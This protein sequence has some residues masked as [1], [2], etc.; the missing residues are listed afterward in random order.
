MVNKDRKMTQKITPYWPLHLIVISFLLF[1]SPIPTSASESARFYI[2]AE[3]CRTCH[4]DQSS[5]NQFGKWS[6]SKHAKSY[7]KLALQGSELITRLS[8]LSE[9]GFKSPICLGCHTTASNTEPWQRD[10]SFSFDEGISCEYCHGP[11]SEYAKEEIM[12]DQDAAHEAGLIF[13]G[14][15]V[16]I[17]CHQHKGSHRAVMVNGTVIFQH[18]KKGANYFDVAAAM[19]EIEHSSKGAKANSSSTDPRAKN[20]DKNY[21]G[22][23]VC[24]ACHNNHDSGYI[25]SHWQLSKHADSYGVLTTPEAMAIAMQKG[26]EAP[27]YEDECL[28]CHSTAYFAQAEANSLTGLTVGVGVQCEGCH[29][30]GNHYTNVKNQNAVHKNVPKVEEHTC[31]TCHNGYHGKDFNY[32]AAIK[33][34]AHPKAAQAVI[35]EAQVTYKTPANL[36]LNSAG[37]KLYVTCEASDSLIVID[38][39]E[40][41]VL[42]EIGVMNLPH[43]VTLSPDEKI[44]YVSNRGSDSVSVIDATSHLVLGTIDVGDEPH[45]LL[46]NKVGN[47]LVVANTGSHDISIV[48]LVSMKE[49]KRLAGGRGTW[50]LV[51]SPNQKEI[52]ATNNLSHLVP[53]RSSSLSELTV[54]DT[55]SMTVKNRIMIK[56]ANL[57]QGID[58]SPDGEFA[59]V[60]LLRTKNLVPIVRVL[61][62]WMI[63]NGFAIVWKDGSVDQLLIDNIDNHFADPTDV[64]IT[65]DGKYGLISGGGVDEI[66]VIDIE[67]VKRLLKNSKPTDRLHVI[68]NH[69]GVSENYV[70]SRIKVGRGP[71]GLATHGRFVYV[72]DALD[73]TISVIDIEKQKRV[74]IISLNGPEIITQVRRGE[75]IFHSADITYGRQYTCHSCHP[76]GGIDGLAYDISPDG[77]GYNP[78]DNRTLRGILDTAPFKWTGKNVSLSRQCG[79]RL[80]VFFTR[81][82]PFTPEQARDLESY[83]VTIPRNPNR[84]LRE[85]GLTP[86]QQRG[87]ELFNRDHTN[88]G[89]KIATIDRCNGCHSGPY[90][91]NRRVMNVGTSSHLDTHGNFDV[92][93]LNNIYETAPYLH[94]GRANTLEEIWTTYNPEDKHGIT[95]DMTKD[96][97][98]DLIEYLKIL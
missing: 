10:D 6:L 27:Q 36:A 1:M 47:K 72:A 46:T 74:D 96:Q 22:Y 34:I 58:F 26:L 29:G 8:G 49:E 21:L 17:D 11:G 15:D 16:C 90:F 23:R 2:G 97:L 79:P 92:P 55:F 18:P 50:G 63:T 83:I 68:P 64:V 77:L 84:Y 98:N 85:D 5:G 59:L 24:S 88:D 76:D 38:T 71:R 28:R 81:I 7:A 75:R 65:P 93:H 95:N 94:D 41:K 13:P 82:D 56:D 31:L 48:D 25:T 91:T 54:L 33:N 20:A 51:A 57:L 78:V 62:G 67:A 70:T 87:K 66:A 60:T 80:A 19:K 45:D 43:G 35:E 44:I 32:L 52:V 42:A 9:S 39:T 86:A 53:F 37:T 89:K 40:R 69:L 4:N 61:Q 30:P 3:V 12:S 14:E 73:D